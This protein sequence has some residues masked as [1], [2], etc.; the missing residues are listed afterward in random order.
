M[1][2]HLLLKMGLLIVQYFLIFER[3]NGK[4]KLV[5]FPLVSNISVVYNL[6]NFPKRSNQ[7]FHHQCE[8]VIFKH[9]CQISNKLVQVQSVIT[10]QLESG[11]MPWFQ[12]ASQSQ[13]GS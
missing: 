11:P 7:T 3:G 9:V 5:P 13:A 4:S 8:I 1:V 10:E 12:N 6:L 2:S